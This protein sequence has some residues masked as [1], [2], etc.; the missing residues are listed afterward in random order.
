[1]FDWD[2]DCLVG[3]GPLRQKVAKN[4]FS[5][6]PSGEHLVC[7]FFER[8]IGTLPPK[9]FPSEKLARYW[10]NGWFVIIFY[11]I[12]L[13][14]KIRNVEFNNYNKNDLH[15]EKEHK[16]LHMRHLNSFFISQMVFELYVVKRPFLS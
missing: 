6:H 14:Q 7:G 11:Y 2:Q 9:K 13:Q 12:V 1:M 8:H 15:H 3:R 5:W 16:K 10:E 4:A